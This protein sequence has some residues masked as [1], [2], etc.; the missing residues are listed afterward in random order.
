MKIINKTL[1]LTLILI[2]AIS[3]KKTG[4]SET[5][6]GVITMIINQVQTSEGS[7]WKPAKL[8]EK[9][10]IN[11]VVRTNINS[12][13]E[14]VLSDKTK[15]LLQ[16]KTLFVPLLLTTKNK[17]FSF[18]HGYI[19]ARVSKQ[20]KGESFIV[21]T[22]TAQVGV[23]GTDFSI[24]T[25]DSGERISVRTGI[26]NVKYKMPFIKKMLKHKNGTIR[27][28]ARQ[29]EKGINIEPFKSVLIEKEKTKQIQK[30]ADEILS[31][32]KITEKMMKD[33]SEI[34]HLEL[35][36]VDLK[37]FTWALEYLNNNKSVKNGIPVILDGNNPETIISVNGKP[38]AIYKYKKVFPAGEYEFAFKLKQF[39]HSVKKKLKSG[40]ETVTIKAP[41]PKELPK[42][43]V[44][45][46]KMNRNNRGPYEANPDDRAAN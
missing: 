33:F 4:K 15:I 3:C 16:E 32:K 8:L 38:A 31:A 29:L 41:F 36:P 28:L 17:K 1:I 2:S 45:T 35:N 26:V 42:S 34:T 24:T 40:Q 27:A 43:K 22:P 14:I 6:N 30:L 12:K 13:S 44:P 23:R 11:K 18:K 20:K 7:E 46:K 10:N 37:D 9:I 21:N 19:F 5:I 25:T 39:N